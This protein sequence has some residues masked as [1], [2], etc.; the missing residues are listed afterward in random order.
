MSPH[1]AAETLLWSL[2][3]NQSLIHLKGIYLLAIK[4]YHIG[5]VIVNI[6]RK[7]V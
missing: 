4:I 5:V 1:T 2:L 7:R 6:V 3:H